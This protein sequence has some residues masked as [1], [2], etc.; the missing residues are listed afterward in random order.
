MIPMIVDIPLKD[1][2][3][4]FNVL[5]KND[6]AAGLTADTHSNVIHVTNVAAT[7][8]NLS[9]VFNR[10]RYLGLCYG[11]DKICAA[12]TQIQSSIN[13]AMEV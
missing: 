13:I 12:C 6:Y 4:A 5:Y 2:V 9:N 11:A 3:A 10:H 8:Q 1:N 7:V